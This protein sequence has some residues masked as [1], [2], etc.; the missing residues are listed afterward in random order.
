MKSVFLR[1]A[2]LLAL[3]AVFGYIVLAALPL[4]RPR[5]ETIRLERITVRDT[6][7]VWGVFLREELVL[8]ASDCLFRQPEASRISAGAELAPGL[9]SP[10]A[11]I[12]TA[13]LDGYE[14]L[15]A[16]ALTVPALRA[17]C[18]DRRMPLGSPGKLIT[19]S[20][21][22]F[23]A[24]AESAAAAGLTPGSRCTLECSYWGG[25]ELQLIEIGESWQD[26]TPLHFSGSGDMDTVMYLR[27]VSGVLLLGEYTGLRLP[28]S[29]LYTENDVLYT[30]V[31]TIG[32]LQ[33]TPVHVLY[34]AGD[35]KLVESASLWPGSEV[36]LYHNKSSLEASNP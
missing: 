7:P 28:D 36:I 21:F 15:S 12:Y 11:G 8:P 9:C 22:D 35:Y 17:L 30:D 20:R 18:G 5:L 27:Q 1:A 2:G 6:V 31:L 4:F 23:Y 14:H 25:V 3:C 10:S 33:R 29:A 13:W 24:L 16:P 34:D 19:S 32:E 26:F